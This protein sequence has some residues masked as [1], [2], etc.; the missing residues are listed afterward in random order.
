MQKIQRI[1]QIQ[2]M[3]EMQ[4]MQ[5]CKVIPHE[6]GADGFGEDISNA[7][8]FL[9]EYDWAEEGAHTISSKIRCADVGKAVDGQANF[10][11]VRRLRRVRI[12]HACEGFGSVRQAHFLKKETAYTCTKKL[13]WML[14]VVYYESVL[15]RTQLFDGQG[16]LTLKSFL[17]I[18]VHN[19]TTSVSSL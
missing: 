4:E 13:V 9:L 7:C 11:L 1:Q 3:Q 5:P 2:E 17:N 14:L 10:V 15:E 18:F 12:R 8:K 19:S 16:I 6:L